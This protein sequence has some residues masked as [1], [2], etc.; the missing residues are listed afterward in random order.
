MK[1]LLILINALFI[2][3]EAKKFD[4]NF[5]NKKKLT[6]FLIKYQPNIIINCTGITNVEECEKDKLK[7]YKINVGINDLFSS[8]SLKYNFKFISISS[9]HLHGNNYRKKFSESDLTKAVNYYAYTKIKSE[10]IILKNS[11]N[12]LILRTNFFGNGFSL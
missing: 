7:A 4:F 8:L 9:D 6:N 12:S 1:F 3:M 10:N 5:F 2:L 11:K